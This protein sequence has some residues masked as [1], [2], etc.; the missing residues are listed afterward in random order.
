V[1]RQFEQQRNRDVAVLVDLW[2]PPVPDSKDLENVELAVS[3]AATV[4]ADLCREGGSNL[5]LGTTGATPEC[6]GGPAS[7]AWLQDAMERL[8]VAEASSEDLLPALLEDALRR[9]EPGTQVVVVSTR[10]NDLDDPERFPMLWGDPAR[11]ALARRIRAISTADD[12]LAEY[13]TPK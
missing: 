9:I 12:E 13:F 11:R 1:V 2:Q 7:G 6:T 4:L 10:A 8:A 3:F 5:L